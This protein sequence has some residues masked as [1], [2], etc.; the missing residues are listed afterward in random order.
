M[1]KLA[2]KK[3]WGIVMVGVVVLSVFVSKALAIS[4][5]VTRK[6]T[7]AALIDLPNT[8]DYAASAMKDD[9]EKW[10]VWT[11]NG[12]SGHDIINF[13]GFNLNGTYETSPRKVMGPTGGDASYDSVH[14]CAPSVIKHS[15]SA[16]RNGKEL[17]LLYY[18]CALKIFDVN[19]R[20]TTSDIFTQTC[21]AA[22]EDGIHWEKYNM[23]LWG[24]NGGNYGPYDPYGDE[25]TNPTP[26][27]EISNFLKEKCNYEFVNGRHYADLNCRYNDDDIIDG[28]GDNQTKGNILENYG[29]GQPVALSMDVGNGGRQ[30]WLYY[31]RSN[32]S[33]GQ[34]GV[35][36]AK[37]W[38]GFHFEPEIR[39]NLINSSEIR[40]YPGVFEGHEGIFIQIGGIREDMAFNYSFDG[41]NWKHDN[42]DKFI[43]NNIDNESNPLNPNDYKIETVNPNM[44]HTPGH[45]GI[46][47][48]KYGHISDMNNIT[49]FTGEGYFGSGADVSGQT[50]RCVIEPYTNMEINSRGSTWGIWGLWGK[51]VESSN[52]NCRAAVGVIKELLD[53]YGVY[54]NGTYDSKVDFDCSGGVDIGDLIKWYKVYKQ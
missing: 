1:I 8:Y 38:D 22:S 2:M 25:N 39:T 50:L 32:G 52:G 51:F 49:L 30:I 4:F 23:D 28:P 31:Y 42:A 15:H 21:V 7:E 17:Y 54:K 3:I 26:V 18:E 10:K 6:Q 20:T 45:T 35:Y 29:V 27:I 13:T 37:S 40:Y 33:W 24:S 12:E 53:W 43:R 9:D 47:A 46:V 14:T 19:D 34:R 41:I 48:N 16:L 44:C 36:L 11:C 5:E